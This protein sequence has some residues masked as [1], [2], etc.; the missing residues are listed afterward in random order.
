MRECTTEFG[1]IDMRIAILD[2]ERCKP[3]KCGRECQKY[4]PR[5]RAGD[6]TVTFPLRGKPPLIVESLCSGCGI[7]VKKCPF[8]A[9]QIVNTPE[10]IER[11]LLHRFSENAFALFRLPVVRQGFVTGLVGQNGAGKSTALQILG[12]DLS[13]NLGDY[14]DPPDIGEV[15]EYFHGSELQ[16]FFTN[17]SDGRMKCVRKPQYVGSIP[18]LI[19]GG[20]GEVLAKFDV[21]GISQ[22]LIQELGLEK[23]LDRQVDQLSGG[24]LQKLAVAVAIAR[25]ANVFLFDEPSSF[26]DVSERLR[27]GR[28][29]RNIVEDGPGHTPEVEKKTVV[30][31][32]HD[33]A[34]LDFLSDFVCLFYGE[35]GAY[36]IVSHPHSVREGIN[37]FLDGYI[38][39]ENMRFRPVSLDLM[40]RTVERETKSMGKPLLIWEEP[41]SKNYENFSLNV[42]PGLIRENEVIGI[43]GPNGIGKSTFV[44]VLA[45][46]EEPSTGP[47]PQSDEEFKVSYKPQYLTVPEGEMTGWDI[48]RTTN[49]SVVMSP[50]FRSEIL[51]PLGLMQLLEQEA[52]SLSGGELQKVA[53]SAALAQEADL[54]LL[55]EPSAYLSVED[56][57]LAAKII[58]RNILGVEQGIRSCFVVE[59]D[60][61]MLNAV[62]D[63]IMVFEGESGVKGEA[64]PPSDIR[65]GM[66][67]FLQGLQIT[68]RR[69]KVTG[70]PRVNKLDSR[71]DKE[72]KE[73]GEYFF[74]D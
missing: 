50:W 63:K 17:L 49:D 32:E 64:K 22:N 38:P 56:R 27:V 31:V 73:K 37:I 35:P 43:L 59:H 48:L 40:R 67:R 13:P 51:E 12:G 42:G 24:E 46:I 66:N 52:G 7:C 6:E 5:V 2:P 26:L 55:D 10:E 25:D 30:C 39:D 8:H 54:Y 36:G 1:R 69:D 53:I 47:A 21:R 65:T 45:G 14:D 4:C 20:V 68:F 41:F 28:A 9:I 62:A 3:R 57:L 60:L 74:E 19:K 29:I 71:L 18:K 44:K 70:R 72:Q 23:L 11:D 15:I 58:R 33:L 61:I 34:L 16:N